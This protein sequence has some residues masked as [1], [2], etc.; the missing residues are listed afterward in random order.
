MKMIGVVSLAFTILIT[1]CIGNPAMK[2]N[3]V[4]PPKDAPS[5]RLEGASGDIFDLATQQGRVSLVFFGYTSCPDICP[6][7]LADWK[8]LKAELGARANKVN[9]VFISVDPERDSRDVAANYA[10]AFDSSFIGLS[11]E[12]A[13]ISE[14]SA[15]FGASSFRDNPPPDV[16]DV[17]EYYNTGRYTV[18]HSSQTFVIDKDGKLRVVFPYGMP[19][20]SMLSD[21]RSLLR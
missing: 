7:T 12:P 11:G 6:T 5:L 9:F 16:E 14:I 8:R 18:S 21:V 1:A 17:A 10:L 13:E 20:D 15:N 19:V 3:E 4:D 2:G